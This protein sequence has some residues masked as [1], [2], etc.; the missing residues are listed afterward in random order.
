MSRAGVG[1]VALG[2]R[3]R[4]SEGMEPAGLLAEQGREARELASFPFELVL[5]EEWLGDAFYRENIGGT[6]EPVGVVPN[7]S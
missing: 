1:F 5:T 3:V 6:G 4:Q 7:Q 2:A